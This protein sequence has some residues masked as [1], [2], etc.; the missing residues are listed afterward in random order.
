MKWLLPICQQSSGALKTGLPL[1]NIGNSECLNVEANMED[2]LVRSMAG[3]MDSQP[4]KH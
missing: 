1:K 4:G 3:L 2:Y